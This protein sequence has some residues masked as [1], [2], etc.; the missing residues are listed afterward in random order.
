MKKE[1]SKFEIFSE[2]LNY[3]LKLSG[4]SKSELARNVGIDKSNIT[5]YTSGKGRKTIPNGENLQAIAKALNTTAS[6]LLGDDAELE[7]NVAPVTGALRSVNILSFISCGIGSYNDGEIID[8]ISLPETMF[9]PNK[10]YFA[11]YA[12]GDS[13]QDAGIDEGDLLI[14]ERA[15]QPEQNR[16]G[17][18][19]VDNTT[20]LCKRYKSANGNMFLISA[21]DNYAPILIDPENECFR[22]VGILKKVLKDVK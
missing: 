9:S 22:C 16:I 10:E 13:M 14:F 15:E 12:Q 1:A 8:T 20:A 19:C 5:I 4:M 11:M 7:S 2:R 6:W 3:A 18:F 21:N 17:A